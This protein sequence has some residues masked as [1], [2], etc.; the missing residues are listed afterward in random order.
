MSPFIFGDAFPPELLSDDP[1]PATKK[2]W[3]PRG[4]VVTLPGNYVGR[5]PEHRRMLQDGL[6]EMVERKTAPR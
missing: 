5:C 2:W 3:C 6:Y 4:H 1:R